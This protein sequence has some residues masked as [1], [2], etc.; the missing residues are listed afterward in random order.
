MKKNIF[1]VMLGFMFSLAA[2]A[3]LKVPTAVKN[4]FRAKFPNATNVKWGKENAK[5]YEADFKLNNIVTSANFDGKG[6]W[7][8]TETEI[9][10]NALPDAVTTAIKNKYPGSVITKGDKIEKPSKT[11]YEAD[12]KVNKKIMEVLLTPEGKFTKS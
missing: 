5:E 12:V 3:Q 6:N 8:E 10:A 7:T 11:L 4:A 9:A 1:L 2:I